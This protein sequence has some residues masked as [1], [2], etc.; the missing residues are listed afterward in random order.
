MQRKKLPTTLFSLGQ[1]FTKLSNNLAYKFTELLSCVSD[2]VKD[3]SGLKRTARTEGTVQRAEEVV[4]RIQLLISNS[5]NKSFWQKTKC[6][7][8][9][10]MRNDMCSEFSGDYTIEFTKEDPCDSVP[11]QNNDGVLAFTWPLLGLCVPNKRLS[12]YPEIPL[13]RLSW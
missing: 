5:L 7:H 11:K 13:M 12:K 2:N 3:V 1:S 8:I 6:N 10:Y 9:W 4:L